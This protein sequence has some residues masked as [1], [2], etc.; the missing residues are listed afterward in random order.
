MFE[1]HWSRSSNTRISSSDGAVG[2]L[3]ANRQGQSQSGRCD[4]DNNGGQNQNMGQGIGIQL[5]SLGEDWR[6]GPFNL[7]HRDV[8]DENRCLKDVESDDLFDDV[9]LR[10]DDVKAHHHYENHHPVVKQPWF[11]RLKVVSHVG[12]L[13]LVPGREGHENHDHGRANGDPTPSS[14]RRMPRC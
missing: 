4:P 1:D 9:A 14:I 2:F 8:K 7:R 3:D 10:D 5:E 12:G 6:G 11:H 13:V